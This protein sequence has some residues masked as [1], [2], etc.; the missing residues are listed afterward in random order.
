[1]A[2]RKFSVPEPFQDVLPAG[3]MGPADGF[4]GAKDLPGFLLPGIHMYLGRGSFERILQGISGIG[5]QKCDHVLLFYPAGIPIVVFKQIRFDMKGLKLQSGE[6]S[7]PDQ[8]VTA[9]ESRSDQHVC[10]LCGDHGRTLDQGKGTDI[11][12]L[13]QHFQQDL[14]SQRKTTDQQDR[15]GQVF[16]NE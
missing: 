13:R 3:R 5:F 15:A 4:R 9:S 7:V 8:P 14:A 16:V 6:P 11:P 10:E 1:M 2:D 12:A